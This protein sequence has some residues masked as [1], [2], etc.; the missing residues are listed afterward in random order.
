MVA[1]PRQVRS[2][3]HATGV[4]AKTDAIDGQVIAHFVAG[5]RPPVRRLAGSEIRELGDLLLRRGQMLQILVAERNRLSRSIS[6]LLRRNIQ[7]AITW[8][9]RRIKRLGSMLRV[10]VAATPALAERSELLLTVPRVGPQLTLTL[11]A[12]LPEFGTLNRRQIASLVGVAPLNRD[13]GAFR[14]RRSVWRGRS[15]AWKTLYIGALVASRHN[16]VIRSFHARLVESGK[17]NEVV[18]VACMR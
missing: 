2:F 1:N 10:L 3:A 4:L 11:T 15:R 9:R 16:P 14:G 8:L 13:S 12:W 7:A 5:F 18:L 6:L 17:P